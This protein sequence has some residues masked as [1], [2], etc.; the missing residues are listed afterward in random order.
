M[1]FLQELVARFAPQRE[2]L[3]TTREQRQQGYDKG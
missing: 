2:A 1:H 3:L